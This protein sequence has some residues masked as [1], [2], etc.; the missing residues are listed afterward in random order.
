VNVAGNRGMNKESISVT[1]EVSNQAQ[2]VNVNLAAGSNTESMYQGV[3]AT[4]YELLHREPY[5][6]GALVDNINMYEK[7]RVAK[8][9][10][11]LPEL[12][13]TATDATTE[14]IQYENIGS[15]TA[16]RD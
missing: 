1:Y 7:I 3:D 8:R 11:I 16:S 2:Y 4:P 14:Q 15:Q 9:N 10:S 6:N 5:V 13:E 12:Y